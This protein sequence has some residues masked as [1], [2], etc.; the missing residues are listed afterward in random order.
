MIGLS[1]TKRV[2]SSG[3]RMICRK[4][5]SPLVA[6]NF[7]VRA[8]VRDEKPEKNGL[9][10]FFEHMVFKGTKNFPGNL[11]SRRVEAL[12]G[13]LNAGTSLDTTD[14]YL[15]VPTEYWRE[16]F[17]LI[18]E[19]LF[20]PL[21]DV[22]DIEREKMVVIQEIHL[23]EDDPD[24]RLSHLLHQKVF[25][26]TPYGMP[27]S[28]REDLVRNLTRD[29]LLEYQK[30]FYHL[31]N[32]TCVVSGNIDEG[33]FF[34]FGERILEDFPSS[35]EIDF[36]LFP[37]FPL[38]IR[39]IV[40]CRMDVCQ[41]YG[42][43]GFLCGGIKNEDFNAL[44]LLSVILGDGSGSRLNIS[45][46]ENQGLV[47]TIHT[48]YSYYEKGG[49]FAVFYTF[50]Q[51]NREYIEDAIQRELERLFKEPPTVEELERAKNLLKSSFYNTIETTLGSA[52]LLGRFDVIDNV[53]HPLR[54]LLHLE[55]FEQSHLLEVAKKYFDM[56]RATSILIGP[57]E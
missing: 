42:A 52:E 4:A 32:M 40:E 20:H 18:V 44:R 7:W 34:S 57:G 9:A 39:Q 38:P 17:S 30:R 47:D 46:R 55:R 24:E 33:E 23:D 29:D 13:I 50:S 54:F 1:Y 15:V 37:P 21:F 16:A 35:W 36:S 26:G 19:L 12:G 25:A 28:G 31:A 48:T 49:I 53:D 11:L 41:N 3:F 43:I 5:R 6:I 10:H 2:F 51:G 14:F 45:L 22:K 8:G 27:I 56:E